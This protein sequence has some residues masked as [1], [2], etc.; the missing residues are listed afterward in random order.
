MASWYRKN[1]LMAPQ[2]LARA[3]LG[4]AIFA[5]LGLGLFIDAT[6]LA[7]FG[8]ESPQPLGGPLA[9]LSPEPLP[10]LGLGYVEGPQTPTQA[11]GCGLTLGVGLLVGW[12]LGSSVGLGLRPLAG[13]IRV[14]LG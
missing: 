13:L 4:C 7:M 5:S 1:P 14:G 12:V 2:A 11:L 9:D 3:A 10:D 8:C 6:T